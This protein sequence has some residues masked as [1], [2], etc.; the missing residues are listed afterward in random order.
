MLVLSQV[1]LANYGVREQVA[2]HQRDRVE[3]V[4]DFLAQPPPLVASIFFLD[5]IYVPRA[6][7]VELLERSISIFLYFFSFSTKLPVSADAE[8]RS[9]VVRVLV[10]LVLVGGSAIFRRVAPRLHHVVEGA[11]RVHLPSDILN[12]IN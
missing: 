3:A 5:L 12:Q 7:A 4:R 6:R 1:G 9:V 8:L 11:P 2:V 10:V